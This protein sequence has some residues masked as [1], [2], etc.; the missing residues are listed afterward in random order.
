M[1]GHGPVGVIEVE[2]TGSLGASLTRFL[3]KAGIGSSK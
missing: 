1:R 3:T 2:S